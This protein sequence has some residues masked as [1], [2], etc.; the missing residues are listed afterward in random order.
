MQA[1]NEL[2]DQIPAGYRLF[3]STTGDLN[4]DG[5][6][7]E[8]LIIKGTSAD[9]WKENTFGEI[10]DRNRRGIMIFLSNNDY[11]ELKMMNQACFSSE[12]EEGGAYYA[13]ELDLEIED[14]KL[15]IIYRHG[16]YGYWW[17]T[18]R[19]QDGTFARI[20]YD[21]HEHRG[22]VME[23]IISANF[24]TG[25]IKTLTNINELAESEEDEELS[26]E[27]TRINQS[28]VPLGIITDFDELGLEPYVD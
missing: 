22:P 2:S 11:L 27:W 1:S 23:R 8:A 15:S 5:I 21:R 26:E 19:Y 24:L 4:S 25:R 12:N 7:D 3:F 6:P 13:P 16:R 9:E 20:G 18:F 14:Q 10:V 17:H 28:P